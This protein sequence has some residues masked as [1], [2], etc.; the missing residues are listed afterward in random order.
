MPINSRLIALRTGEPAG[1]HIVSSAVATFFRNIFECLACNIEL[2]KAQGGGR[3]VELTINFAW[4]QPSDL[5]SPSDRIRSILFLRRFG[6]NAKGG[7]GI[8]IEA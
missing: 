5:G 7:K 8:P 3:E 2:T 4:G 1:N 6:K